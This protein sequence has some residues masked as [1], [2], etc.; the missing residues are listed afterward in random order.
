MKQPLVSVIVPTRNNAGTI[1][2]CL[3]SIRKQ[4]Y[5]QIELIVVDNGSNDDTLN[6][7]KKYA[8][9][10]YTHGPER[11]AQRNYGAKRSKGAYVLIV[12]SDI[13]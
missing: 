4:S 13:I 3:N 7:A 9:A 2:A 11:S 10:V 12:D 8:D 1:A 6:I 5:R